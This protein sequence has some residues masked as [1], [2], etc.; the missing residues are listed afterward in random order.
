MRTFSFALSSS[1][2]AFLLLCLS[3]NPS[4]SGP[5]PDNP[6][7]SI[8]T[9]ESFE[10]LR[11]QRCC[12]PL[13]LPPLCLEAQQQIMVGQGGKGTGT[14][15]RRRGGCMG[16]ERGGDEEEAVILCRW[17]QPVRL[18]WLR[19]TLLLLPPLPLFLCTNVH[20]WSLHVFSLRSVHTHT[21]TRSLPS[22]TRG[23]LALG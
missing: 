18:A 7:V 13:L 10:R 3:L 5:A 15:C 12:F 17:F 4:L 22:R 14:W 23:F 21:H 16:T 11:S 19:A 20:P 6:A 1:L 9:V 2:H 8:T